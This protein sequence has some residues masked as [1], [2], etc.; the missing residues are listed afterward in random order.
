MTN[1]TEEGWRVSIL[2]FRFDLHFDPN[3]RKMK[4]IIIDPTG[5]LS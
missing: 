5:D 2:A 1:N 4:Y 3:V